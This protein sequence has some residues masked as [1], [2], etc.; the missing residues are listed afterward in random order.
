L[1]HEPAL[2]DE[3]T[4]HDFPIDRQA[5]MEAQQWPGPWTERIWL[6]ASV[7]NKKALGRLDALRASSALVRFLSVE[8]LLED[9][10]ELSLSGIHWVIVGGESGPGFRPMRHEWARRVRDQC[11]AAGITKGVP[12]S[13]R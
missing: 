12:G 11:V 3:H 10:G 6:G 4:V 9:L 7:E 2:Q 5:L 13:R 1:V 8:P